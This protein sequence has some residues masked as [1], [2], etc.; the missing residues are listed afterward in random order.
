[1]ALALSD[2]GLAFLKKWERFRA[3]PYDDGYGNM[4]IGL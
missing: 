3:K 1:M 2:S 4:T